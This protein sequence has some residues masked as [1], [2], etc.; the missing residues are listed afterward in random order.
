MVVIIIGLEVCPEVG[1]EVCPEVCPEADREADLVLPLI[2]TPDEEHSLHQIAA[3]LILIHRASTDRVVEVMDLPL[4]LSNRR[5]LIQVGLEVRIPRTLQ[6]SRHPFVYSS[7]NFRLRMPS[8]SCRCILVI[9]P[10]KCTPFQISKS[11][12]SP[13]SGR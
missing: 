10:S 5:V 3:N 8:C 1:L 12:S 6:M 13:I 7:E 11:Q 4:D 2:T 9:R